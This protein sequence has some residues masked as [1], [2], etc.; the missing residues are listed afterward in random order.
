MK[1]LTF[2]LPQLNALLK[3]LFEELDDPRSSSALGRRDFDLPV[4]K[5]WMRKGDWKTLPNPFEGLISP[6]QVSYCV[7]QSLAPP[8]DTHLWFAFDWAHW[9]VNRD[10]MV[11]VSGLSLNA[12]EQSRLIQLLNEHFSAQGLEFLLDGQGRGFIRVANAP[13]ASFWAASRMNGQS[14][15]AHIPNAAYWRAILNEIQ[16]LFYTHP[17]NDLRESNNQMTIN[18]LWI[19][20]PDST[21]IASEQGVTHVCGPESQLSWFAQA[22]GVEF[23][24]ECADF[25]QLCAQKLPE[26][27]GV[28]VEDPGAAEMLTQFNEAAAYAWVLNW[29]KNWWAPAHQALKQGQLEEVELFWGPERSLSYQNNKAWRVWRRHPGWGL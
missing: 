5:T 11:L 9:I 10:D 14:V 1:K 28:Y 27:S 3:G 24:G 8:Q 21:P 15:S 23:L 12:Q 19:W 25:G 17:I 29:E 20:T 6:E 26:T 18:S 16:M 7:A 4:L 2:Y 22:T 13:E